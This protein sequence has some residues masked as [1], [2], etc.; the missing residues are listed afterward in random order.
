MTVGGEGEICTLDG[1]VIFYGF[2]TR[3]RAAPLC[4][5]RIDPFRCPAPI[6]F[7]S[8]RFGSHAKDRCEQLLQIATELLQSDN[9]RI[10]VEPDFEFTIGSRP[11]IRNLN[12]AVNR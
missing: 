7:S 1:Q 3:P 9:R 6:D 4:D 5:E 8:C 12:L 2:Q 10:A 11:G